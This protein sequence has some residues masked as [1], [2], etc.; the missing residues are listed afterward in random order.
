MNSFVNILIK[1]GILKEDLDYHLIR[2]SMVVI[3][4]FF[5]VSEMVSIRGAGINSLHQ[6]RLTYFLDVS[7]FR[8]P[9]GQLAFGVLG[10]VVSQALVL[11][12]S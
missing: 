10:M 8:H 9:R 3:F 7:G 4:L 5:W 11:R 6:Q 12:I 1:F 2:A